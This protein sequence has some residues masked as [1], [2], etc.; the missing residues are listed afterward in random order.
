MFLG[1]PI[2]MHQ[3]WPISSPEQF[4]C[5]CRA[6]N[7]SHPGSR[8]QPP[9]VRHSSQTWALSAALSWSPCKPKKCLAWPGPKLRGKDCVKKQCHVLAVRFS[10]LSSCRIFVLQQI[11]RFWCASSGDQNDVEELAGPSLFCK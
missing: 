11:R 5:S 3:H 10:F 9:T 8:T 6:G 4:K 2:A 1:Y 7:T